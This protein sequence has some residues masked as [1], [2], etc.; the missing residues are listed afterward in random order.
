MADQ[1]FRQVKLACF[2]GK[3]IG[4]KRA[5]VL[6]MQTLIETLHDGVEVHVPM[7]TCLDDLDSNSFFSG[8]RE[9]AVDHGVGA[10]SDADL[11]A[12]LDVA[13]EQDVTGGIGVLVERAFV[14]GEGQAGQA[15]DHGLHGGASTRARPAFK[16]GSAQTTAKARFRRD[17][18]RLI[19][20][21]ARG[22]QINSSHK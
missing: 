2:V 8:P 21:S 5:P 4:L 13:L 19:D 14:V 1:Q 18:S 9:R 12:I 16:V 15:E 20:F 6:S 11:L 10:L 3:T 22:D 7:N 17:G